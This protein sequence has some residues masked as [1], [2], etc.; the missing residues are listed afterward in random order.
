MG[1]FK[2]KGRRRGHWTQEV[3][4]V[5]RSDWNWGVSENR[6]CQIWYYCFQD[7]LCVIVQ[8]GVS[9]TS[10]TVAFSNFGL[11]CLALPSHGLSESVAV[12]YLFMIRFS[13]LQ[14]SPCYSMYF[15]NIRSLL[16]KFKFFS[17]DKRPGN[18]FIFKDKII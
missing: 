18:F 6:Q 10:L 7:L 9:G 12:I 13:N 17:K 16:N 11:M 15:K 14:R 1:A 8:L 4:H 2:P 3:G 5:A